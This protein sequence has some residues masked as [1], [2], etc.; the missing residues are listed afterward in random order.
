[1]K[2]CLNPDNLP[3]PAATYSQIVRAGTTI[4]L[5]G[6]VPIDNDGNLAGDDIR[7]QTRRVIE[8]TEIGSP[9]SEAR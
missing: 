9:R 3:R 8:N 1:M 5:A 6:M 4:F 7:T 2:T